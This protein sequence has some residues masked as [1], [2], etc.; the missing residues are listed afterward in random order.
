M[1]MQTLPLLAFLTLTALVFILS[2]AGRTPDNRLQKEPGDVGQS[3]TSQTPAPADRQLDTLDSLYPF[4][5]E[6]LENDGDENYVSS[7]LVDGGSGIPQND[8]WRFSPL[9]GMSRYSS[10]LHIL[11]YCLRRT[12]TSS[13]NDT[14]SSILFGNGGWKSMSK[15]S[16]QSPKLGHIWTSSPLSVWKLCQQANKRNTPERKRTRDH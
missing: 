6:P 8:T 2:D 13:S 15:S 14:S 16:N 1:V 11:S 3:N 12:I 9:Q 7:L 4:F 10:F 5:D